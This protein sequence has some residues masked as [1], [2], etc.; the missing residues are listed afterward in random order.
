M[1]DI[2]EPINKLGMKLDG[3]ARNKQPKKEVSYKRRKYSFNTK[4]VCYRCGRR[5]HIQ[6]Y[7]NYNQSM[8]GFRKER[9]VLHRATRPTYRQPEESST[10]EE[11]ENATNNPNLLKKM[12]PTRTSDHG[13]KPTNPNQK[14]RKLQTP[15]QSNVQLPLVNKAET[16]PS[17][18]INKG[19]IA[20][21]SVRLMLDTG[22]GV[23]AVK[24]ELFK[25]TYGDVSFSA[26]QTGKDNLQR[27]R[28][29][30]PFLCEFQ[31]VQKLANDSILGRDFLQ[32]NRAMIDLDNNTITLKESE[33]Q[34]EQA[35]SA[36]ALRNV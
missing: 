32:V 4:P 2:Q 8:E 24:E 29:T 7:C 28:I 20:G 35:C 11:E 34:Q 19:K 5:G 23:S 9:Q 12:K 6:Y 36:S 16:Y 21:K 14:P 3:I 26:V 33:N 13:R 30:L 25:E 1:F 31:V 10:Y 27:R 18:L 17:N 22:A 15:N